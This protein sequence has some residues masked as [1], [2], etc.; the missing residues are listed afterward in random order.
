MSLK[1]FLKKIPDF[2]RAPRSKS[3]CRD[4]S[5]PEIGS[6]YRAGHARR[7]LAF[8]VWLVC[9]GAPAMAMCENKTKKSQK[10]NIERNRK[11]ATRAGGGGKRAER[12]RQKGSH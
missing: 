6:G 5:S 10:E 9:D 1:T 2:K 4:A 11:P 8:C 3:T 12:E 7:K